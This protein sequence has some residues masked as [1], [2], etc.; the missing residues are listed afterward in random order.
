MN[1]VIKEDINYI[2]ENNISIQEFNNKTIFVTGAT[3]FINSLFV[4]T[5]LQYNHQKNTNIHIIALIRNKEKA[6]KIF[7]E[8]LSEH[9]T[10]VTGTVEELPFIS[11]PIHYIIHGASITSSFEFVSNPVDT[12]IT[13]IKGTQNILELA[14][15]KKIISLLY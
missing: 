9:L 3:G 1:S 6:E 13:A 14:Y 8:F 2:I 4:K 15:S 12:I 10:F 5:I 7:S 11:Q